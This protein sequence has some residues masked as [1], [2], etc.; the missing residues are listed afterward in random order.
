MG[1]PS[2]KRPEGMPIYL[3]HHATTPVD[4]RVAAVV[5]EA[6]TI[7]FGNANSVEHLYGEMAADLVEEAK[8]AVADLVGADAEGVYFTSGATDSIN[9]AIRHSLSIPVNTDLCG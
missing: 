5:M 3:D 4:P 9:L 2:V 6:M 1:E 7:S 8:V